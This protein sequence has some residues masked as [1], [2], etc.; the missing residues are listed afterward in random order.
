MCLQ[1]YKA[2]IRGE[3]SGSPRLRKEHNRWKMKKKTVG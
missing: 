1:E 3:P 2:S